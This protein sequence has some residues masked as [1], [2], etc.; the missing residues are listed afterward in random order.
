MFVK[1][2][3]YAFKLLRFCSFSLHNLQI[4][5]LISFPDKKCTNQVQRNHALSLYQIQNTL[6]QLLSILGL[7]W[8]PGNLHCTLRFVKPFLGP[9]GFRSRVRRDWINYSY[10]HHFNQPFVCKFLLLL[11]PAWS[12]FRT[13][14]SKPNGTSTSSRSFGNFHFH[15]VTETGLP[16]WR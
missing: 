11:L 13:P 15:L 10:F 3:L 4:Y 2:L 12:F 16:F 8:S 7:A 14:Y 5:C 6:F 9:I 1:V